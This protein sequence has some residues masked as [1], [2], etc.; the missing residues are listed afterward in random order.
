MK[1]LFIN[2]VVLY[3]II[4]T[5]LLSLGILLFST[6]TYAQP[7]FSTSKLSVQLLLNTSAGSQNY[8]DGFVVVFGPSFTASIGP[9]D[10]YKFTNSDE[11]LAINRNGINLSIEGR[12]SVIDYDTIP[13]SIWKY[14]QSSYCL[15][16]LGSN[17]PPSVVAVLKDNYLHQDFPI[18][19]TTNTIIQ[20]NLVTTDSASLDPNRLCVVFKPAGLLPLGITSISGALKS[21][22]IQVDWKSFN[23]NLTDKYTVERSTS[24]QE[25]SAITTVSSRGSSNAE[26]Y[27][28]LDATPFKGYNFYRIK[29][30]DKSGTIKYSSVA[31]VLNGKT[32]NSIVTVFPNP[33]KNSN[34]GLQMEAVPAGN[35]R[36]FLYNNAG[37]VAY[38]QSL[39]HEGGSASKSIQVAVPIKKGAYT[40]LIVSEKDK[41]T[42]RVIFD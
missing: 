34:I 21:N 20:Y 8:A 12:P 36:L 28:W 7:P 42:S 2:P 23:D 13:I 5:V 33:V 10:S 27:G 35:Y 29:A 30:V 31:K 16:I 37:Q 19:L 26:S 9:E 15:K 24:G 38:S 14:R 11:N 25:F 22:G 4:Y 1:N 17:F 39:I 3:R 40:L 32:E 18:D 6:K 41:F